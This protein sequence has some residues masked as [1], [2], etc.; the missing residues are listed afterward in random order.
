[1]HAGAHQAAQ[2]GDAHRVELVEVRARD[3]QEAHALEQW[4]VRILGLGH[5]PPVEG[6]P[7]ELAVDEPLGAGDIEVGDAAPRRRRCVQEVGVDDCGAGFGGFE[8]AA[9]SR[10]QG[11]LPSYVVAGRTQRPRLPRAL[12]NLAHHPSDAGDRP[13]YRWR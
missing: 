10:A 12:R 4:H 1:V 7:G 13:Q 8:H 11:C 6:Q 9:G 3:R 5:Y 2:A